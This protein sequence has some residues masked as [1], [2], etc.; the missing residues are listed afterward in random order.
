[1]RQMR[2]EILYFLRSVF[3]IREQKIKDFDKADA[4]KLGSYIK[5]APAS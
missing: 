3:N 5:S 4:H 1:M 2:G